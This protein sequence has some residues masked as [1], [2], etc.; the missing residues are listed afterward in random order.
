VAAA[1][2]RTTEQVGQAQQAI[3]RLSG[4]AEELSGL[5]ARFRV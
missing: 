4:M 2:T 5:V 1:A 3:V